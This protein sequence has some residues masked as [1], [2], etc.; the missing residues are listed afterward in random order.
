MV[1][2]NAANAGVMVAMVVFFIGMLALVLAVWGT[3]F[4]KA[5][6]SFWFCLLMLVPLANLIW[7]LIFAF[8][9]WPIHREL[10]ALRGHGY[11][12]ASGFPVGPVSMPPARPQG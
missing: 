5:G 10:K 7:L 9:E 1:N 8:S 4:K 11:S 3:I 6:Y 2:S 12:G